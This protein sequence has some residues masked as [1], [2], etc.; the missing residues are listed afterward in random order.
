MGKLGWILCFFLL[1]SLAT[2]SFSLENFSQSNAKR[3]TV[4][5]TL[6]PNDASKSNV[7]NTISSMG[8][9]DVTNVLINGGSYSFALDAFSLVVSTGTVNFLG[10]GGSQSRIQ[11]IVNGTSSVSIS[12]MVYNSGSSQSPIIVNTTGLVTISNNIFSNFQNCY[13]QSNAFIIFNS[14]SNQSRISNCSFDGIGVSA[15]QVRSGNL[16]VF[17]CNFT[18]SKSSGSSRWSIVMISSNAS[19]AINSSRFIGNDLNPNIVTGVIVPS[20]FSYV[21]IVDSY[22]EKNSISIYVE[23]S[24]T[25]ADIDIRNSTFNEDSLESIL[26]SNS[27]LTS[28][29]NIF[30]STFNGNGQ[31]CMYLIGGTSTITRSTFKRCSTIYYSGGA[32]QVERGNLVLRDS[33]ISSSYSVTNGG[34]ISCTM[35]GNV[36]ISGSNFTL[37]HAASNGGSIF[38][39]GCGLQVS[40]SQFNGESSESS[41]GSIYIDS[42]DMTLNNNVFYNNSASLQQGNHIYITNQNSVLSN[43]QFRSS[44]NPIYLFNALNFSS[45][46]DQFIAEKLN[47]FTHLTVAGDKLM[48]SL[49]ISGGRFNGS[50]AI[51]LLQTISSSSISNCTFDGD[52]SK[53]VESSIE[54]GEVNGIT[55]FGMFNSSFRN[56]VSS[57]GYVVILNNV[58]ISNL[59]SLK[60][61]D[62]LGGIYVKGGESSS[63]SSSEFDR[64]ITNNGTI[65]SSVPISVSD[66][67]FLNNNGTCLYLNNQNSSLLRVTI[68]SSAESSYPS[69]INDGSLTV[70]DSNFSNNL[71]AIIL[72]SSSFN[73]TIN[74]RGS[75]FSNNT[76]SCIEINGGE[77]DVNDSMFYNYFAMMDSTLIK[78]ENG[79]LSITSSSFDTEDQVDS[80]RTVESIQCKISVKNSTFR[81]FKSQ[82]LGSIYTFNSEV[83]LDSNSFYNV[84][85]HSYTSSSFSSLNNTFN[86]FDSSS[87]ILLF[88]SNSFQSLGDKFIGTV[89][90]IDY[91]LS[92]NGSNSIDSVRISNTSF[93]GN[94]AIQ[95][96][97]LASNFEIFDSKFESVNRAIDINSSG[98][99]LSVVN[100]TFEKNNN[101]ICN[102]NDSIIRMEGS[103]FLNNSGVCINSISSFTLI[104]DSEFHF[105]DGILFDLNGNS[106]FVRVSIQNSTGN[107]GG[108]MRINGSLSINESKFVN[109][110]GSFLI[111]NGFGSS[112]SINQTVFEGNR[113]TISN[114]NDSNVEII[115]SNFDG[116]LEFSVQ[117]LGKFSISESNFTSN[118]RC[119]NLI[120]G[121]NTLSNNSF[122]KCG[123]N[124][125]GGAISLLNGENSIK[126]C[127]FINNSA[128]NNLGGAISCQSSSYFSLIDSEFDGNEAERG[129]SISLFN[130]NASISH[131]TFNNS[132]ASFGDSIYV[133]SSVLHLNLCLLS[134][135]SM[136]EGGE[137]YGDSIETSLSENKFFSSS[138]SI[139][140]FNGFHS[141]DDVFEDSLISISGSSDAESTVQVSNALMNRSGV[142][143]SKK[144]TAVD[145]SNC[146]FE[147]SFNRTIDTQGIDKIESLSITN[148]SF[149]NVIC[150]G[151]CIHAK[152]VDLF[153]VKAVTYFNSFGNIFMEGVDSSARF[154]ITESSFIN[155]SSPSVSSEYDGLLRLEGE[156]LIQNSIFHSNNV[157]SIFLN[158]S[159]CDHSLFNVSINGGRGEH[160]ALIINSERTKLR[161]F[162]GG[163]PRSQGNPIRILGPSTLSIAQNNSL[164]CDKIQLDED[165]L[166]EVLSNSTFKRVNVEG[167]TVYGDPFLIPPY[168]L[169]LPNEGGFIIAEIVNLT[170]FSS[171]QIKG[172]SVSFSRVEGDNYRLNIP[173][174]VGR[175]NLTISN[176]ICGTSDVYYTPYLPPTVSTTTP[177]DAKKITLIGTGFGVDSNLVSIKVNGT[178]CLQIVASST[179][180]SCNI[181]FSSF[182]YYRV[183]VEVDG[184]NVSSDFQFGASGLIADFGE[185]DTTLTPLIL[186]SYMA[187]IQEG[188]ATVVQTSSIRFATVHIVNRSVDVQLDLP[189]GTIAVPSS[190]LTKYNASSAVFYTR[191]FDQSSFGDN[192]ESNQKFIKESL[193]YS[194]VLLNSSGQEIQVNG[195]IPISILLPSEDISP[196]NAS[197]C[198]YWNV[199]NSIWSTDGCTRGSTQS[200]GIECL[201]NHLTEFA[202]GQLVIPTSSSSSSS[203]SSSISEDSS[204]LGTVATAGQNSNIVPS[205]RW[206]DNVTWQIVIGVVVGV[207]LLIIIAA[208]ITIVM[209]R[210][211]KVNRRAHDIPLGGEW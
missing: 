195:D 182:G 41:G 105:N 24:R 1:V 203:S 39:Q 66:S 140:I 146:H 43:N 150:N 145:F 56:I 7:Q 37:N 187:K 79:I 2:P 59:D 28:K 71:N 8:S 186:Y 134:G 173:S 68:D 152:N 76:N 136:R 22:F 180:L 171:I 175:G 142:S 124:E 35:N 115:S 21:S 118:S 181:P 34:A 123:S 86:H 33:T 190:I 159:Q 93:Y 209:L 138:I 16:T 98:S 104:S 64:V 84:S 57:K 49:S 143:L 121:N 170:A 185:E 158:C 46:N 54:T 26:K 208:I 139:Q 147:G 196:S 169:D 82:D 10:S 206:I 174:G 193:V 177:K 94:N 149:S 103:R 189:N 77:L 137:I 87:G 23:N 92:L 109:N 51:K 133:N 17:N 125:E 179:Q 70:I 100:S 19:L 85:I 27:D 106:S 131:S 3:A 108:S 88:D 184:L 154:E 112:L 167:K 160:S 74:V 4:S 183:D 117:N 58:S 9:G 99:S 141:V 199:K 65:Y 29:L 97:Q 18:R 120:G 161:N 90:G 110:Q 127:S 72:P 13:P 163:N 126:N 111:E 200:N 95:L 188:N 162:V 53:V 40:Q 89:D 201:C 36:D 52:S 102:L 116:N 55:Q 156:G 211:R 101:G 205:S 25:K 204:S 194:V 168:P 42:S 96:N 81:E 157:T 45:S 107:E 61:T 119:L 31:Q 166:L 20:S 151:T 60:F 202:F 172:K 14:A 198:A 80:N 48:N 176:A 15:L 11:F 91:H 63:I 50:S 6:D 32:I 197:V 128:R 192:A 165:S 132:I 178:N 67:T 207:I 114:Q 113:I 129:G 210:R 12:G 122:V 69:V 135:N 144:F 130:C 191:K 73:T 148:S 78:C 155:S 83:Q 30:G 62:T 153:V 44:Q 75:V 5:V 47:N 164:R 38:A